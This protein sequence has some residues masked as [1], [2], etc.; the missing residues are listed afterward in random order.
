MQIG[1]RIRELRLRRRMTVQ[2]L[3]D[4]SGLSKGFVSQVE[5]EH[6]CP[7][8]ATLRDF[9][10]ALDTTV[11]WLVVEED[12]VPGGVRATHPPHAGADAISSRIER[13]SAHPRRDLDLITIELPPGFNGGGEFQVHRGEEI[14][15]C[16]EGTVRLLVGG[17]TVELRPGESC[18]FDARTPHRLENHGSTVSRCLIATAFASFD[19][20]MP[21]KPAPTA[22]AAAPPLE[23]TNGTPA[24]AASSPAG[25]G[26]AGNGAHGGTAGNGGLSADLATNGALPSPEPAEATL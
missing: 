15:H 2:Q 8:L 25:P 3:A 5:N 1:P 21:A 17:E 7:S 26:D 20:P 14:V 11:A 4:A 6:T 19:A 24:I 13:L 22:D 9:A 12:P 10:T 18:H 16:V 23:T